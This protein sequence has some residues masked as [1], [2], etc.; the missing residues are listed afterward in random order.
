MK[1]EKGYIYKE[2]RE[3]HLKSCHTAEK[4]LYFLMCVSGLKERLEFY[5]EIKR[6]YIKEYGEDFF[7]EVF[8]GEYAHYRDA[9]IYDIPAYWEM[10]K[11]GLLYWLKKDG[12]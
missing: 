4:N 9:W 12:E 6:L 2:E 10:R 8:E 5:T 1:K 11:E 3:D 7:L